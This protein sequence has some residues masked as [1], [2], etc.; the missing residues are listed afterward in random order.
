MKKCDNPDCE[1]MLSDGAPELCP[2]C[3]GFRPGKLVKTK[4]KPVT[5]TVGFV[6]FCPACKEH[7]QF[8]VT[9][10]PVVWT[11][12]GNLDA[13]T[14][15]PSLRVNPP[16]PGHVSGCPHCHLNVTDGNIHFHPDSD[17]AMAGQVVPLPE[18]P[19]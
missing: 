3:S 10:G 14:F 16:G 9:Y 15:E 1:T 11:F 17:H 13:P 8:W 19:E 6:F 2:K 4:I 18:L 7:H 5:A 12:N